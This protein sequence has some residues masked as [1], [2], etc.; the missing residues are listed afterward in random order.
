M[1]GLEPK[2][3]FINGVRVRILLKHIKLKLNLAKQSARE[4]TFLFT[5]CHVLRAGIH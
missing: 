4:N 1:C 3:S 2:L 5:V